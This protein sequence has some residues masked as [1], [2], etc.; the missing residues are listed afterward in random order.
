[1]LWY[2]RIET[3]RNVQEKRAEYAREVEEEAEEDVGNASTVEEL[4]GMADT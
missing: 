2:N 4:T 1:M 3:I